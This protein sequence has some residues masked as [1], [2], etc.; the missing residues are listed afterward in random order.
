MLT[1]MDDLIIVAE[2]E[3]EAIEHLKEVLNLA[4]SYNL[5]IKWKKCCFLKTKIEFLDYEIK[6]GSVR[7]SA[8]KTRDINKYKDPKNVKETQRFLG[9]TGY[10]RKFIENYATIAKPLS[11]LVRKN[12]KFCFGDAQIRS[13]N[14]LKEKVTN[15]PILS[16]FKKDAET[17]LHTDASKY[18]TAAIL[19]QRSHVDNQFHPVHYLSNKTTPE[20][21]K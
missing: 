9:F 17:E 11:D 21:E 4:A 12:A 10:F 2:T 18:G 13:F 20:Q 16:I 6:A 5:S 15:R 14:T 8:S 7:P 19:L 1:Y 3:R